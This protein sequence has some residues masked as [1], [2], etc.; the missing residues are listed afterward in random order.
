MPTGPPKSRKVYFFGTCVIDAVYPRAGLAAVRLLEREGATV[1]FP[2]EQSCCGQPAFNSGFPD[3]AREVARRQLHAFRRDYPVVVPSGSCAGMMKH[4]YPELF[5]GD[6]DEALARRFSDR[7]FE[8]SQFLTDVLNIRLVD[9]GAPL[10]VTWHSSCHAL[11]EMGA[12]RE[13]KALLNQLAHVELAELGR[14]YECCGFGGTFSVKYPLISEAMVRDK[15]DDIVQTG[16][17]RVISGDCACLLHIS[18]AMEKS[19][20]DIPAQHLAEFLW[21]RTHG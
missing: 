21:E 2:R 6:R 7:V 8:L 3:E 18:G 4:H 16:A 15:I 9:R 20:L 1:V 13:S 17:Q 12:I 5:A 19:G 10:K 11:R 14:E